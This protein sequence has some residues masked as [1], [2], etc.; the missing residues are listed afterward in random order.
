MGNVKEDR[1]PD[2]WQ[3]NKEDTKKQEQKQNN[4]ENSEC[5]HCNKEFASKERLRVHKSVCEKKTFMR[6]EPRKIEKVIKVKKTEDNIEI[7]EKTIKKQTNKEDIVIKDDKKI[8]EESTR[9]AEEEALKIKRNEEI[10]LVKKIP[11]KKEVFKIKEIPAE[12]EI[13][14]TKL[15]KVPEIKKEKADN[16]EIDNKIK[17]TKIK[18]ENKFN[19]VPK[20]KKD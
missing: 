17:N 13:I 6:I 20:N 7:Q 16:N 4:M 10:E 11:V 9:K 12:K 14:E 5:E 3:R 15:N 2:I 19:E 8:S 1:D 18:A